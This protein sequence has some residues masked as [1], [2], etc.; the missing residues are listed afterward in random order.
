M[1][2]I[3]R[4]KMETIED[5]PNRRMFYLKSVYFA[6]A[7]TIATLLSMQLIVSIRQHCNFLPTL[8]SRILR[9]QLQHYFVAYSWPALL[10]PAAYPRGRTHVQKK[11]RP[12]RT[13]LFAYAT[14]RINRQKS[15]RAK[16]PRASRVVW[17]YLPYT[18][19][20]IR[21]D[22]IVQGSSSSLGIEGEEKKN[23]KRSRA[24][25]R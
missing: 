7:Y 3:E 11:S 19:T 21:V 23:E 22:K 13:R 2:R 10:L 9:T 12:T 20:H 6:Y 15:T 5:L 8:H 18:Y 4:I 24:C 25:T 14:G 17:P 16:V 1:N